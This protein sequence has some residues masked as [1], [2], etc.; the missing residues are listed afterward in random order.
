MGSALWYTIIF[1]AGGIGG[2]IFVVYLVFGIIEGPA[3]I[4]LQGFALKYVRRKGIAAGIGVAALFF[5]V[6]YLK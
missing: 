5:L 3:R 2:C 1:S 6:R 4:C